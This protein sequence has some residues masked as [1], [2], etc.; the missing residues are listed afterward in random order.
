MERRLLH[1]H[2]EKAPERWHQRAELESAVHHRNDAPVPSELATVEV[3]KSQLQCVQ[4][5][6]DRVQAEP[7]REE[8]LRVLHMQEDWFE[9]MLQVFGE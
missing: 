7:D 4:E 1:R 6:M 2:Q 8:E 9:A 5:E 3:L